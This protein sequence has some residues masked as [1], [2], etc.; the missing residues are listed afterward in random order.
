MLFYCYTTV[1]QLE[2]KDGDT[3]C[4]SFII[5]DFFLAILGFCFHVKLKI[6]LSK[7]EKLCLNFDEDSIKSVDIF[8]RMAIFTLLFLVIYGRSYH[9]CQCILY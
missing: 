1:V 5:Q 2:I 6:V 3:L 9:L 7:S 4:S 8:G